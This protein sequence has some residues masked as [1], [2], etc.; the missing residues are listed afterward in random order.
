LYI[1]SVMGDLPSPHVARPAFSSGQVPCWRSQGG[2][3]V[4]P[5]AKRA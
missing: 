2:R 3:L 1:R 4:P 5:G